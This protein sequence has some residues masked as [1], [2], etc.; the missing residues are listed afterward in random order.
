MTT[1]PATAPVPVL[2]VTGYL[3]AGKTTLINR[4]LADAGGRRIAAIVNDFG[5]I[6][7]DEELIRAR[8][9]TVVGLANGCVCCTLQGDLLRTLKLLLARDPSPDHIIVEASGV[10]DPA[11]IIQALSDPVL[12]KSTRLDAVLCVVDAE[13]LAAGPARRADPLWQAQL[14][15]ASFVVLTKAGG[16][17]ARAAADL[18]RSLSPRGKPPVIDT[19]REP[20]PVALLLDGGP[21]LPALPGRRF[22]ATAATGESHAGSRFATTT[23]R[24]ADP[25]SLVALQA[26]IGAL[27]PVLV[28]AKGIF[29]FTEKPGQTWLLQMVGQRVT[30]APLSGDYP[31]G[32]RLVLIAEAGRLDGAAIAAQLAPQTPL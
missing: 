10:A 22:T 3:G 18:A 20:L 21:D 27:A 2:V 12:W 28:R 24:S 11:G 8:T 26:L 13:D 15:A 14:A 1:A 23:W 29:R 16:L 7:I 19:A 9:D 6:N 30:L 31:E 25:V 4:L 5:A 17:D 32:C